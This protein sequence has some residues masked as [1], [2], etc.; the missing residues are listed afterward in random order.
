M[1]PA[2]RYA[3]AIEVLDQILAGAAAERTLTNW[4]RG[5]RFAGSKDR[6]AIRDHV[7]DALRR[8]RSYSAR[9]GEQTGRGAIL[10]ALRAAGGDPDTVFSGEKFAP[11]TLSP[12]ERAAGA[13][14]Q[15]GGEALDCPDWLWSIAQE[16]LGDQAEATFA[17]LRDPAPVGLRVNLAKTTRDDVIARL[18]EA[19]ISAR[20]VQHSP[21]ALVLEGRPRGLPQLPAWQDGLFELQDA[22]SQWVSDQ[23]PLL[24]GQKMVDFCAGGGGKTLAVA[25]RVKGKFFAFDANTGRMR[26]LPARSRR[27]GVTVRVVEKVQDLPRAS[28]VVVD[29]PCSGSGTWRRAPDAKWRLT[30]SGLS[31]LTETQLDIMNQAA[32]LVEP[33]G[34]LVYATCSVLC[35]ENI[36]QVDSFLSI[37]KDF[38]KETSDQM[39][40][41]A[42]ADGYFVA[43]LRRA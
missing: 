36:Q 27:A 34:A 38:S 31:E 14:P 11:A 35:R 4:A 18:A 20:P 41:S 15:P 32:D 8:L 26:D 28:T 10:G 9:G 13:A 25:G 29:V 43:V 12:A 21:A 22:G 5:H 30:D 3:A 6:A 42:S 39:L 1:T 16:D 40:P 17:C 7:F 2:A 37:R 23:I 19:G 24:V 33:G